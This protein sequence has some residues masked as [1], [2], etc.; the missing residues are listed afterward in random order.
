MAI[1]NGGPE[2][3]QPGSINGNSDGYESGADAGDAGVPEND[4]ADIGDD[5]GPVAGEDERTDETESQR[6][7]A[8]DDDDDQ[9]AGSSEAG[10]R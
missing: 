3:E 10:E 6:G 1:D 9:G 8:L 7:T 4:D 2:E 5:D